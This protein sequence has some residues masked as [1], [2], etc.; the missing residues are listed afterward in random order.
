MLSC[1]C[2]CVARSH[3]LSV[4]MCAPIECACMCVSHTHALS[5]CMCVPCAHTTYTR[6]HTPF[7]VCVCLTSTSEVSSLSSSSFYPAVSFPSP[8]RV[9][10]RRA[11]PGMR[12]LPETYSSFALQR[13]EC[14]S[15]LLQCPFR[16][17]RILQS[18]NVLF[19]LTALWSPTIA[20]RTI[21]KGGC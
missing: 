11:P 8:R 15:F 7:C 10:F 4:C 21:A 16:P 18:T 3:T 12:R 13:F 2:M 14:A 6:T 9:S 19:V 5:V 17:S 20:Q 1:T